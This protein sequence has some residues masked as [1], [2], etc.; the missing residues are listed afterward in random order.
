VRSFGW[1]RG[2]HVER[3]P[4]T[5]IDLTT[6]RQQA[7]VASGDTNR[8]V[9]GVLVTD[10]V[11]HTCSS[12]ISDLNQLVVAHYAATQIPTFFIGMEGADYAGLETMAS[13]AGAAEHD[14][15]CNTDAGPPC[16]YCDVRVGDGTVLVD[17]LDEIRSQVIG[18]Q[19]AVPTAE[20][21]LVDLESI[22]VHFTPGGGAATETLTRVM[23]GEVNCGT[24]DG[25]CTD[26]DT[27]PTTILLC[28]AT[29]TRAK[30]DP[31]SSVSIELLCEGS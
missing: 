16:H 22:E 8:R 11:P 29:C 4:K 6:Q 7:N 10:G 17:A 26:N 1:P 14:L 13:G 25:Y 27:T 21:G 31:D 23:S 2:R 3:A 9:I 24:S 20:T 15:C 30:S 12:E 5:I 19:F 28:P 18:C